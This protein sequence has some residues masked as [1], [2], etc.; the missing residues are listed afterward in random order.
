LAIDSDRIYNAA[1]GLIDGHLP[2]GRGDKTAFVDPQRSLSY[3][4]LHDASCQMANLLRTHGLRREDRIAVLALDSVDWPVMFLGAIRAGVIP[5][6]LNTLLPTQQYA[7]MLADSRAQAL[8]VS[9]SLLAAIEPLLG[10]LDALRRIFVLE[11]TGDRENVHTHLN[12]TDEL[13]TQSI[14]FDTA[15]TCRD[16]VAFWL[17]SSGSTGAPK[18]V[19]HV[20]SSM[21]D[22]ALCYGRDVL[23]L[24]EDDVVLS[25]AKLFFAYGLGNALSFPLAAGATTVLWPARPTPSDMFKLLQQHQPS[26][27]FGVPTL[28]AAML[29]D[30]ACDAQRSSRRLR[31]CV[32]AGEAL[33]KDVGERWTKMFD[34]DIIDGVGSTEMLHIYLSNTPDDVVYGTSGVA[35]PGYDLRLLDESGVEVGTD[36]VGELLVRGSSAALGYWNQLSKSRQTF[37]GQWTRSGD[38]YTRDQQG[39]YVYCGRTDDMFK[40]SGIWVSPFEV[41]SALISHTDVLEAAV[42]PFEDDEGLTKPRA[43]VVLT[44]GS[45]T[46]GMFET[47]REHVQREIGSWKYPRRIDFVDSLPKTATG[48]IQRFKLRT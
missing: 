19:Q 46:Q 27:F 48:K 5:I 6:A 47:L 22:T 30:P 8:F 37:T 23:A 41:E 29:N 16:E 32:S 44:Q 28:Y 13:A 21:M 42:V 35:V 24:S 1:A 26:V 14:G 9:A 7:Y 38:K 36:Q 34:V 40:V 11:D 2:A 4:E 3:R 43:I 31:L 45:S 39:R 25:A 12:F 18:G 33:P 10:E 15:P 17:Y 20:H